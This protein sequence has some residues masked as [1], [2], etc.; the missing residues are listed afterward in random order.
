MKTRTTIFSNTHGT[1]KLCATLGLLGIHF[2]GPKEFQQAMRD[3][4][5]IEDNPALEDRVIDFTTRFFQHWM[6]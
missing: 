1:E 4:L 2:N 5:V 6:H 3:G